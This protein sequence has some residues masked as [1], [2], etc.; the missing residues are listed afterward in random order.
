MM[1]GVTVLVARMALMLWITWNYLIISGLV[2]KTTRTLA[3]PLSKFYLMLLI[4]FSVILLPMSRYEWGVS[5][6]V[7]YLLTTAFTFFT[8]SQKNNALS[9]SN[10]S[11]VVS[12][13]FIN[14]RAYYSDMGRIF[15]LSLLAS[16]IYSD[17]YYYNC[18]IGIGDL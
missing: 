16:T 4:D 9:I 11:S 7:M 13:S 14:F 6:C 17:F 5:W 12:C 1:T 3:D 10:W 8:L 18:R 15:G 2:R